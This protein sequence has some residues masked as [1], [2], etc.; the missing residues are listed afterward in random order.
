[1]TA[2]DRIPTEHFTTLLS[3]HPIWNFGKSDTLVNLSRKKSTTSVNKQ[4]G[5]FASACNLAGASMP[6]V[7]T[8]NTSLL[9]AA[10]GP[11]DNSLA[12][13]H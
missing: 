9:P 8:A 7:T 12:S 13:P 6:P 2:R 4:W 3:P 11:A 5:E 1:M 10:A